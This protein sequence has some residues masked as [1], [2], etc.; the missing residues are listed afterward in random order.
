MMRDNTFRE[1]I[2]LIKGFYAL[3][4]FS[5][6]MSEASIMVIRRTIPI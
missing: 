1:I 6:M 2:G 5:S 4:G 3:N